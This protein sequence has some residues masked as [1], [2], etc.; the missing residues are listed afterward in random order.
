MKKYKRL[1]QQQFKKAAP[2]PMTQNRAEQ[3]VTDALS[4]MEYVDI[5]FVQSASSFTDGTDC[6]KIFSLHVPRNYSISSAN[7]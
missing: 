1:G 7:T 4:L 5:A 6:Y 3:D 2:Y